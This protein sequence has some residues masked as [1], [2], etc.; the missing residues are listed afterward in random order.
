MAKGPMQTRHTWDAAQQTP[1][2]L[3]LSLGPPN[4]PLGPKDTQVY[5]TDQTVIDEAVKVFKRKKQAELNTWRE[6][7]QAKLNS[8]KPT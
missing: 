3:R 7:E 4:L 2:A 8:S 5:P 6:Q 1:E